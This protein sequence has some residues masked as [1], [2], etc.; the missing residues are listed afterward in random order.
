MKSVRNDVNRQINAELANQQ[1]A[2]NAAVEQIYAIRRV[3]EHSNPLMPTLVVMRI[4]FHKIL[5]KPDGHV[6]AVRPLTSLLRS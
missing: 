5:A 3:V 6:S 1:K 2:S 4:S